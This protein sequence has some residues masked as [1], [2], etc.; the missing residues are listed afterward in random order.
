MELLAVSLIYLLHEVNTSRYHY[1]YLTLSCI[2][3]MGHIENSQ[4]M[5]GVD[6][7][8]KIH[9]SISDPTQKGFVLL[10]FEYKHSPNVTCSWIIQAPGNPKPRISTSLDTGVSHTRWLWDTALS[11]VASSLHSK[12][13]K[14]VSYPVNVAPTGASCCE[15]LQCPMQRPGTARH[16]RHQSDGSG[17]P[18][19]PR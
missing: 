2:V 7:R 1:P 6:I 4:W 10:R 18:T 13:P 3:N 8:C 9:G 16:K 11:H 5:H 14:S 17:K 15:L 19:Q 12:L